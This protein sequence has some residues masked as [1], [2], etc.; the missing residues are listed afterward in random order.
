MRLYN[1]ISNYDH[2]I[3]DWNGTLLSD[4]DIVLETLCEQLKEDALPL[5]SKQRYLDMFRFPIRQP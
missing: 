5:P 2:I 4:L 1:K 3:W